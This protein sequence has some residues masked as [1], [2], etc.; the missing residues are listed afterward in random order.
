[1][2]KDKQ[3]I[4][5]AEGDESEVNKDAAE[6]GTKEENG[7]TNEDNVGNGKDVE[8]DKRSHV[9]DLKTAD[10]EAER[11]ELNVGF[12]L[13]SYKTGSVEVVSLSSLSDPTAALPQISSTMMNVV[14]KFEKF[15]REGCQLTLPAYSTVDHT[16]NW[17][18]LLVRTTETGQVI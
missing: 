9:V 17:R 1:M 18:H 10:S 3:D 14:N 5:M 2:K 4:E 6:A 15:V 16:G 7:D 13:S 8:V 11:P 12:R